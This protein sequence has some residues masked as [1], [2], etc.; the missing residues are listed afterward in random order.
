MTSGSPI[1]ALDSRA[2]EIAGLTEEA[3]LRGTAVMLAAAVRSAGVTT[4]IGGTGETTGVAGRGDGVTPDAHPLRSEARTS[5]MTGRRLRVGA[6]FSTAKG[7]WGFGLAFM[8]AG[9]SGLRHGERF[10]LVDERQA[11]DVTKR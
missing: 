10:A 7:A 3:R 6:D 11:A 8:G 9:Y 5:V 4:A 1:N 2:P